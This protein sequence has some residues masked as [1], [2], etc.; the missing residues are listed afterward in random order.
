MIYIKL[1]VDIFLL[2][3]GLVYPGFESRLRQP[4][5]LL[6][7]ASKPALRST[8]PP[9]EW[10]PGVERPGREADHLRASNTEIHKW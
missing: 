2:H 6:C 8:R 5:S 9:I 1:S 4:I 7:K 10:L 3:D